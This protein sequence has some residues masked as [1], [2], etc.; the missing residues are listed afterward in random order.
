[1]AW[2]WSQKD[3]EWN[4]ISNILWCVILDKSFHVSEP[5][6]DNCPKGCCMSCDNVQSALH[7]GARPVVPSR[8]SLGNLLEM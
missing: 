1:M 8:A 3:L 6:Y 5:N 4:P 7:S 2:L